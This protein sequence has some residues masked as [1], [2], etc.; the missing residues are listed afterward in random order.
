MK[1]IIQEGVNSPWQFEQARAMTLLGFLED[2]ESEAILQPYCDMPRCWTQQVAKHALQHYKRN[3]WVKQW[4]Q[5]FLE[6]EDKVRAWACF[7]L[8]LKC[9]DRRFSLWEPEFV[10]EE[11]LKNTRMEE[12][13][14]FLRLNHNE[15]Q[16]HIK[17]NEKKRKETFLGEKVLKD[18]V[19]PWMDF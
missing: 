5:K 8:F 10:N 2:S 16:N 19:W 14:R 7:K 3:L 1:V 12:R 17:E 9:V 18:K 4:F 11:C 15:V 13:V 6:N